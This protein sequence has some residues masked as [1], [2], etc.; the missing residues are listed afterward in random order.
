MSLSSEL[1]ELATQVKGLRLTVPKSRNRHREVDNVF[2]IMAGRIVEI[3][4][5]IEAI[6][7]AYDTNMTLFESL[8]D[9]YERGHIIINPDSPDNI[10]DF[11]KDLFGSMRCLIAGYEDAKD[12]SA[13]DAPSE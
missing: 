9:I 7:N 10:K 3:A 5:N 8:I 12:S 4:N 2:E 1:K 11:A 6:Q 13:S